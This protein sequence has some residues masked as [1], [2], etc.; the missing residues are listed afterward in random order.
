MA[1]L[2][3]LSPVPILNIWFLSTF[4]SHVNFRKNISVGNSRYLVDGIKIHITAAFIDG[5]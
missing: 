4:N 1:I 5:Q 3:F 2:K